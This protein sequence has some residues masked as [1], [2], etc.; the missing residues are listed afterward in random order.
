MRL[1]ELGNKEDMMTEKSYRTCVS[2]GR[3]VL[4]DYYKIK[5]HRD[6]YHPE[7]GQG[8]LANFKAAFWG[9]SES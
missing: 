9:M 8:P 5:E 1:A 2:C 3:D 6:K 4:V 7:V